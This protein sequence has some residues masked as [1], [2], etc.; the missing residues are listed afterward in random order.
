MANAHKTTSRKRT[1]RRSPRLLHHEP[2][3]GAD[4]P[5]HTA[6]T[7]TMEKSPTNKRTYSATESSGSSGLVTKTKRQRLTPPPGAEPEARSDRSQPDWTT[8]TD[9][10]KSFYDDGGKRKKTP[11][12]K[13][14]YAKLGTGGTEYAQAPASLQDLEALRKIPYASVNSQELQV[15]DHQRQ[16]AA[17]RELKRPEDQSSDQLKSQLEKG[18]YFYLR[19]KGYTQGEAERR[20]AVNVGT[21]SAALKVANTVGGL[22][23]DKTISPHLK[24]AKVYLTQDRTKPV[25]HDKLM[26]YYSPDHT[27]SGDEDTIGNRIVTQIESAVDPKDAVSTFAPLY[28]PIGKS[29]AW[30][31]ELQTFL[32]GDERIKDS[33][34]Q[35]LAGVITTVISKNSKGMTFDQFI[36]KLKE[37]LERRRIDP[38][39]PHRHLGSK[40]PST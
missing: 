19:N 30:T 2:T 26:V 35:T 20:I 31:E 16:K 15:L 33:F 21:Q 14:V 32:K 13:E 40:P 5:V 23:S 12:D 18:D 11:H 29:T 36:S 27:E 37:S 22:F 17:G 25:K 7:S 6:H 10:Y 24:D 34:T 9:I 28:S 8:L 38:E 4:T 1:R 3:T 39:A